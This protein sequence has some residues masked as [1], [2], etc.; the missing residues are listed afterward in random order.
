MVTGFIAQ[1]TGSFVPALLVDAG[2]CVFSI[3]S[4]SMIRRPIT[5]E[6]LLPYGAGFTKTPA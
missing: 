4:Y 5:P 1:A 2:M 6:D 3:L